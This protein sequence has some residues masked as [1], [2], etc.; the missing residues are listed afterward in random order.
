MGP[1]GATWGRPP[2]K[3][4]WDPFRISLPLHHT[5]AGVWPTSAIPLLPAKPQGKAETQYLVSLFYSSLDMMSHSWSKKVERG[6]SSTRSLSLHLHS[7]HGLLYL[8]VKSGESWLRLIDQKVLTL[9]TELNT[10]L[11]F[12]LEP[13]QMS[14]WKQYCIWSRVSCV[15]SLLDPSREGVAAAEIL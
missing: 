9:A 5:W 7:F 3:F 10:L 2:S 14:L 12:S 8:G 4:A 1:W 11:R 15:Y 6:F 13:G